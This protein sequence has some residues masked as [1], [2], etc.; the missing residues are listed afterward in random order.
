M[1]TEKVNNLIG[2]EEI[3]FIMLRNHSLGRLWNLLEGITVWE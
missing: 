1:E 3:I 2:R